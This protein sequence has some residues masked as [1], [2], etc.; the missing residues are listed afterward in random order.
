MEKEQHDL[1]S[2][3]PTSNDQ[4]YLLTAHVITCVLIGSIGSIGRIGLNSWSDP[5]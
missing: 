5:S 1:E 4:W 3:P 2:K